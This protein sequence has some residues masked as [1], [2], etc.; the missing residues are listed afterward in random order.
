MQQSDPTPLKAKRARL[1]REIGPLSKVTDV[2]KLELRDG[3]AW[4]PDAKDPYSG[5]V[6]KTWE[7]RHK[8]S[9]QDWHTHNKFTDLGKFEAGVP[10]MYGSM[11]E[12]DTLQ[13]VRESLQKTVSKVRHGLPTF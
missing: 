10:T 3:L 13:F 2:K 6:S 1:I 4:L 7:I 9:E 12:N 8:H 11:D 5:W